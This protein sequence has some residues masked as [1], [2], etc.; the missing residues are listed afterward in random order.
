MKFGVLGGTGFLG[1]NLMS[2]LQANNYSAV[3]GSRRTGVDARDVEAIV[4]WVRSNDITHLVN[5]AAECG[6]IGLNQR[7]PAD[8]WMASTL[9]SAAV[10][11]AAR[12]CDLAKVTM[13]GTVCSYGANTPTPF[14]ESDLMC[15]GFPEYTN[16]AY[17]LSKLSGYF[18]ARA[19][20]DQYGVPAIFLMPVNMYGPHDHF[21]LES[22]HVMAALIRKFLLAKSN[23]DVAVPVWGTGTATR[24]FLYAGDAA[25]AIALATLAYDSPEPINI[26][27]GIEVSIRDLAN[28][29]ANLVGYTG[30][31][32]W[33][34]SRPDGQLR[35]CLDVSRIQEQLGWRARTNLADGLAST[36]AWYQQQHVV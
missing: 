10:L 16:A 27:S 34:S 6:G 1:S 18:G 31:I 8:L 2:Y 4:K 15:C 28:T 12:S 3:A 22:S 25:E 7:Q 11:E 23:G 33:D 17:G 30:D 32:V 29:I 5:L 13:I 36:I 24:E 19:Y 26:G 20:R 35:R 21:D 9:I 14:K